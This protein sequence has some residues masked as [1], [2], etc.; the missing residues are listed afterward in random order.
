MKCHLLSE[1]FWGV[2][3]LQGTVIRFLFPSLS[4]IRINWMGYQTRPIRKQFHW[5]GWRW[6]AGEVAHVC[7]CVL[8]AFSAWFCIISKDRNATLENKVLNNSCKDLHEFINSTSR[9]YVGVKY[10]SCTVFITISSNSF[11]AIHS[12]KTFLFFSHI[13]CLFISNIYI[14]VRSKIWN[15]FL[16]VVKD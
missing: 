11:Q 13:S 5:S 16:L 1:R 2:S 9:V 3:S 10:F 12:T 7:V 4:P 15:I 14:Q 6:S 8:A